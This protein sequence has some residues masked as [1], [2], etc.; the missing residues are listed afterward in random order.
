MLPQPNFVYCLW[1]KI[2]ATGYDL[3]DKV[4]VS[5]D[6]DI[7][8]LS[9]YDCF[10]GFW[11]IWTTTNLEELREKKKAINYFLKSSILDVW[12]G[13]QILGFTKYCLRC[14]SYQNTTT[15]LKLLLLNKYANVNKKMAG[16]IKY[17]FFETLQVNTTISSFVAYFWNETT[18]RRRMGEAIYTHRGVMWYFILYITCMFP[19]STNFSLHFIS[20]SLAKRYKKLSWYCQITKNSIKQKSKQFVS[21]GKWRSWENILKKAEAYLN[22]VER[23]NQAKKFH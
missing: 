21:C 19:T 5:N 4:T 14:D 2:W 12:L 9:L 20:V 3:V 7:I 22:K 18:V 10:K 23:K 15:Y 17:L 8:P 13:S 16:H 11:A 6:D 1:H